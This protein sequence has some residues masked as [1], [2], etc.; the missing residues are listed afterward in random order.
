M[1]CLCLC[2]K[3]PPK[4]M[5][6][7]IL[8]HCNHRKFSLFLTLS[9]YLLTFL[10][11]RTSIFILLSF[12]PREYICTEVWGPCAIVSVW[13]TTTPDS[14]IFSAR[15]PCGT[16]TQLQSS[17]L[18]EWTKKCHNW[19]NSSSPVVPT[20]NILYRIPESSRLHDT[21][22]SSTTWSLRT[23]KYPSLFS[24]HSYKVCEEELGMSHS[25]PHF[26]DV[27]SSTRLEA[28]FS[29]TNGA[30]LCLAIPCLLHSITY[31]DCMVKCK[32][33][34]M[35]GTGFFSP[36]AW[37][38]CVVMTFTQIAQA[39]ANLTLKMWRQFSCLM[40]CR[41]NAVELERANKS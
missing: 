17:N 1:D 24:Q 14:W 31:S 4:L 29:S 20:G 6:H 2:K 22:L 41:K 32:S 5:N 23:Q 15:S 7:L 36:V 33:L 10:K 11:A 37:L 40:L 12:F 38:I 19:N 35:K 30:W 8:N 13:T 39:I 3:P 16:H 18:T 27:D 25:D 28:R 26:S 21:H 34:A 9:F